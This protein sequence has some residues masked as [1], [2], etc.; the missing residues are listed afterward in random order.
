MLR[1]LFL[2]LRNLF[3]VLFGLFLLIGR[4]DLVVLLRRRLVLRG[5]FFVHLLVRVHFRLDL[6]VL[7]GR[8][9]LVIRGCLLHY[10]ALCG[11]L[12]LQSRKL[13][14]RQQLTQPSPYQQRTR[15]W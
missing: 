13:T 3:L 14:P 12:L 4:L 15:S 10:S 2:V 11:G 5:L 1:G 6:V 8:L 7:I 9:D